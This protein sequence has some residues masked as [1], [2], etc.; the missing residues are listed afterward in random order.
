MICIKKYFLLCFFTICFH[1]SFLDAKEDLNRPLENKNPKVLFLGMPSGL[2]TRNHNIAKED[3]I[4]IIDKNTYDNPIYKTQISEYATIIPV[5]EYYNSAEVT[6]AALEIFEKTP[7]EHIIA[8]SESD[9]LRA[10]ALRDYLG[11]KGQSLNSSKGFRD[12]SVMKEILLK[13]GIMTADFTVLNNEFDL[14]NFIKTHGYPVIVK[15]RKAY[16]AVET[17]VLKDKTD[18]ENL[19][20]LKGVFDEFQNDK[21]LVERYINGNMY[22]V[23]GLI[24]NGEI[25]FICPS[26]YTSTCLEMNKLDASSRKGYSAS[27]VIPQE[28][29][30]RTEMIS[31]TQKT[32]KALPTPKNTAFFL[33]FFK[34]ENGDFVVCEIAS[35]VGGY[36]NPQVLWE[37]HSIDLK[38]EFIRVQSGI[39]P[40]FSWKKQPSQNY[41]GIVIATT[42]GK[43]KG[44]QENGFKYIKQ[45][46]FFIDVGGKYDTPSGFLSLAAYF[47][48]PAN[49][50]GTFITQTEDL[51]KYF[52]SEKC[53]ELD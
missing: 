42:K 36:P 11:L 23:D 40:S 19:L 46:R 52:F 7:Y 28:D 8:I 32:L 10:G 37:T 50:I 38:Q 12:K 24:Y 30:L 25:V 35:R 14:I 49:D 4:L 45:K 20:K 51:T 26:Q 5:N 43:F 22:H 13:N 9:I 15:P 41:G 34:N 17:F 6:L 1:V 53:W 48:I 16:G 3:K 18:L 2:F 39:P 21:F 44:F 31:F 27:F 47:I 33:E 29:P